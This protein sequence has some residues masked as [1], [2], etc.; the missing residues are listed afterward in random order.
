[1][2]TLS[3]NSVFV[4]LLLSSFLVLFSLS[5]CT[6]QTNSQATQDSTQQQIEINTSGTTATQ[7]P[8]AYDE[9]IVLSDNADTVPAV[10]QIP[11]GHESVILVKNE[12]TTTSTF[13]V[14]QLDIYEKLKSGESKY[15][16][17]LPSKTG[18]YQLK[19]NSA[20]Y[21]TFQVN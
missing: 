6:T 12:R 18:F 19:L 11:T 15:I 2:K 21:G 8:I 3:K 14:P 5:A 9:L 20:A 13:E 7:T 17:V 1:M 16:T 4:I 10:F